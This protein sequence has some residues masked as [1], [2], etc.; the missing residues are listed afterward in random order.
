MLCLD[1]PA[2]V[3]NTVMYVYEHASIGYVLDTRCTLVY[4]HVGLTFNYF[5][6]INLLII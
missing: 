1:T 3:D 5:V 4:Q 6:V 2:S